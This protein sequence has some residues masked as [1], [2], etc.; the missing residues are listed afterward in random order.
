MEKSSLRD[1]TEG[2]SPY[3]YCLYLID[4][5]RLKRAAKWVEK[6]RVEEKALRNILLDQIDFVRRIRKA[7]EREKPEKAEKMRRCLISPVSREKLRGEIEALRSRITPAS[8][9]IEPVESAPTEEVES[10]SVPPLT[11]D[12]LQE[13]PL[14]R[15]LVV[16]KLG[17]DAR[18]YPEHAMDVL[19]EIVEKVWL[20]ERGKK[21]VIGVGL[22]ELLVV[23]EFL[24]VGSGEVL[25]WELLAEKL[26]RSK[27][28]VRECMKEL[29][30]N[31]LRGSGFALEGDLE[32]GLRLVRA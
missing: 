12:Q 32:T 9:V 19:T 13:L 31:Y 14:A 21:H 30:R 6:G 20:R 1:R 23:L 24:T 27:S 17:K 4:E 8:E 2:E 25:T 10:S 22:G 3:D 7:L 18:K 29:Q 5:G 11:A 26:G 15:G 28:Q 16:M